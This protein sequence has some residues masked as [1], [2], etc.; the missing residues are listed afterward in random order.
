MA[1]NK[2]DT[3]SFQVS[4]ILLS[5]LT[6]LSKAVFWKVSARPPISNSPSS[7]IKPVGIVQSASI[8]IGIIITLFFNSF[9]IIHSL[10][11]VTS[12]LADGFSLE[13]EL[14]Q[15]FSSLQD[16][17]QYSGCSQ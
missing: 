13:S 14:Q 5:I 4:S 10:E 8:T 11:L 3:E 17:S 2:I 9:I 16:S 7:L 15:V 6:D 12:A 1:F